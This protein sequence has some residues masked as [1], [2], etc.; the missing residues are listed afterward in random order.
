ML[1]TIFTVHFFNKGILRILFYNH[2]LYNQ[3]KTMLELEALLSSFLEELLY[4]SLNE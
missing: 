3:L 1:M 2:I 4:K